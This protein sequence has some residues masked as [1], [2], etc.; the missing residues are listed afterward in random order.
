[1][2]NIPAASLGP[3]STVGLTSEKKER[4]VKKSASEAS[5]A[6]AASAEHSIRSF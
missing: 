3:G 5:G 4:G 2:L 6:E 1:M